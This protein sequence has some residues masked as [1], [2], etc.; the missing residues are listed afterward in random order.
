MRSK[1]HTNSF[2]G[3]ARPTQISDTRKAI[4]EYLLANPGSH[5]A[6]EI[7]EATD[8]ELRDVRKKLANMASDNTVVNTTPGQINCSYQHIEHWQRS[9]LVNRRDPITN[10]GMPNGTQAWWAGY[11][12]RFNAPPRVA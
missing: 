9:Q 8:K 4:E 11:M 5:N 3:A 12:A 7:A 1:T 2:S 10:A 6:K